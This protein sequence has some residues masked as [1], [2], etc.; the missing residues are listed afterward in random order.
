MARALVEA[1]SWVGCDSVRVERA[2]PDRLVPRLRSAL[3]ALG[4]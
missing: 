3:A 4:A 2:E 1:A